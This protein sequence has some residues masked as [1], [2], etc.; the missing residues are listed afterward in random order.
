MAIEGRGIA[1]LPQSLTREELGDGRL[2]EAGTG[3]WHIPV[4]IRVFRR[5]ASE[6]QA[7]E[8]FWRVIESGQR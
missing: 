4:E 8:A 7:A 3:A 6:P 5:R 2:V 1:W